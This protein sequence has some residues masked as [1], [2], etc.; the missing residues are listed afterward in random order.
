MSSMG[1]A[2]KVRIERRLMTARHGLRLLDSKQHILAD[3]LER[4]QLRSELVRAE[5]EELAR[6]A[7][8]WLRRAAALD[9][10]GRIEA[11]APLEPAGV[12]LRWG[13]AMGVL[14]PDDP[15]CR[16]PA[17]PQKGGSSALSY[18]AAV[19]RSALEAGV[20]YAAVQRAELLLAAELAATRTRQRAVENRWIPRLENE[21]LA[22]ARQLDAQELE[23]SLRLRW[24]A[25]RNLGNSD[26]PAQ[27]TARKGGS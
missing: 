16:L 6:E 9:G 5:W 24:A 11:A 2:G 17:P 13:S 8:L 25:D 27:G 23:E 20:R 18:T 4:V 3:E 7:G 12:Q 19:H 14:Y 1:R 10:S 15:E 21:L 22:I 26:G